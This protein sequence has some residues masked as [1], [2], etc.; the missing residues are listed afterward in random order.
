MGLKTHLVL[1]QIYHLPFRLFFNM[2]LLKMNILRYFP[3]VLNFST[4]VVFFSVISV[5]SIQKMKENISAVSKHFS[6]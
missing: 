1:E 3:D 2:E 4:L 6:Y 5:G